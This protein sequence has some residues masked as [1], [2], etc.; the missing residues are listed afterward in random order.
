MEGGTKWSTSG[1]V[2]T[3]VAGPLASAPVWGWSESI[4]A[5][6]DRGG[7][8]EVDDVACRVPPCGEVLLETRVSG[9]GAG[10]GDRGRNERVGNTS[11]EWLRRQAHSRHV[12]LFDHVA[13]PRQTGGASPRASARF[14]ETVGNPIGQALLG[15]VR[16]GAYNVI[17][18]F[19]E[20]I[21]QKESSKRFSRV[22]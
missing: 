6:V 2:R 18:Q 16:R 5:V 21:W 11:S 15:N 22:C 13:T 3:S 19:Q 8:G 1:A 14:I 4:F 9:Q 17:Y 7:S 20:I 12:S 10:R